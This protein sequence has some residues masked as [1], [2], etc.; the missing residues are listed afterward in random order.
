MTMIS[1]PYVV[2]DVFTDTQFEGNPLAVVIDPPPLS[3]ARMARI[4]AEFHLSETIFLFPDGP[5]RWATRIFTPV[6]ELP[7]AGHPTVGSGIALGL[8]GLVGPDST[9]AANITLA[10]LAGD[11]PVVLRFDDAVVRS[12]TCTAPRAPEHVAEI[13]PAQVDRIV[14]ALG[15]TSADLLPALEPG[16]WSAGVP[17]TVVP[18]ASIDALG[19]ARADAGGLAGLVAAGLPPEFYL[20]TPV[21]SDGDR[22]RAR[23]FAPGL[24]IAEDPATGAAACA[25]AGLLA[26]LADDGTSDWLIE[27]G[28]EMGRRSCIELGATVRGGVAEAAHLGG[29]AVLVAEGV[30][31][32]ADE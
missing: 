28:V 19:R 20:L 11:V 27:Q 25:V 2:V 3:D 31:R 12:A 7:F 22:W 8:A 16:V 23:M 29:G 18:L 21:G 4:A 17:F 30:L 14:A 32:L 15:L 10:E 1:V 6:H 24:G 26:T 13:G 5:G 9:G